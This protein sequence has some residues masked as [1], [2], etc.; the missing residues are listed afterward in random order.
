MRLCLSSRWLC[1]TLLAFT[2]STGFAQTLQPATTVPLLAGQ[3]TPVGEATCGF[4][5]GSKLNGRC[6]ANTTNGW[7]MQLVHVYAGSVAPSSMAP[8]SF[9]F[10]YRP[11]QCA[12]SVSVPFTLPAA[13]S[14]PAAVLAFHAEV[15]NRNR[16]GSETA[17]AQGSPTG[18]NWSMVFAV[19]CPFDL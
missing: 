18:S 6:I 12:T 3:N 1:A 11:A 9:P 13:C 8:G 5:D 15:I 14:G 2:L 10:Q 19:A 7:C 16:A 4:E 17:W